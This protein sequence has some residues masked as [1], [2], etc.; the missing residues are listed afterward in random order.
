[1]GDDPAYFTSSY[2][3]SRL[4]ERGMLGLV[5]ADG[6]VRAL[7]IGA[8]AY[9]GIGTQI[10]I[11]GYAGPFVAYRPAPGL[12]IGAWL[13][14][15]LSRQTDMTAL[16]VA[17]DFLAQVCKI[18]EGFHRLGYCVGPLTP[19]MFRVRPI[20]ALHWD[21]RVWSRSRSGPRRHSGSSRP[22]G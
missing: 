14:D 22:T 6:V 20:M 17:A 1:M 18:V 11:T 3:R 7:R 16:N 4:G 2:E 8:A 19:G 13:V 15:A 10:D 12:P 5:G 9:V 21:R